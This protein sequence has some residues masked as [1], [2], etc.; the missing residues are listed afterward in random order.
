MPIALSHW[1]PL[2]PG[3]KLGKVSSLRPPNPDRIT[4]T[5]A[6]RSILQVFPLPDHPN[7]LFRAH[8]GSLA[9]HRHHPHPFPSGWTPLLCN[10]DS[11]SFAANPLYR[12][13][14]FYIYLISLHFYNSPLGKSSLPTLSTEGNRGSQKLNDL[15]KVKKKSKEPRWDWNRSSSITEHYHIL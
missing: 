9:P 4:K 1:H 15:H 11:K 14:R 7:S 3:R 5:E 6:Q 13:S 10:S 12:I 2:T 8:P